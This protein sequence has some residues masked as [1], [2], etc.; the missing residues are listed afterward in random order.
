MSSKTGLIKTVWHV[1]EAD[2]K[3][4]SAHQQLGHKLSKAEARALGVT[5]S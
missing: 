3:G 1:A 2:V 5:G 4:F